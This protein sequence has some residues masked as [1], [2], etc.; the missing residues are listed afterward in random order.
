MNNKTSE[1]VKI[2][3]CIPLCYVHLVAIH[4]NYAQYCYRNVV[5]NCNL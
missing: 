1:T 4:W 3:E 2:V 5:Y